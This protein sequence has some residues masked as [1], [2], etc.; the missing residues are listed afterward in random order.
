MTDRYRDLGKDLRVAGLS[1]V[2]AKKLARIHHVTKGLTID[3]Y[4]KS[5]GDHHFERKREMRKQRKGVFGH[6]FGSRASYFNPES[7]DVGQS[8]TLPQ[9]WEAPHHHK[10][11]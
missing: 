6:I 10:A 1:K 4:D 2:D 8:S 9:S 11:E 5:L 7:A 3:D